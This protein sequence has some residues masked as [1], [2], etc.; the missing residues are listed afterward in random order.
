MCQYGAEALAK[1]GKAFD[2]IVGW[3]Y[4]DAEVVSAYG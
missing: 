4:P 2:E 3:Y 1:Q